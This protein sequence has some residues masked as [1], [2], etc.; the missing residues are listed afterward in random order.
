MIFGSFQA[1]LDELERRGAFP[2]GPGALRVTGCPGACPALLAAALLDR[3]TQ[4]V[5]FVAHSPSQAEAALLDIQTGAHVRGAR[6]LP[7][8]ETLPF[9]DSDPHVEITS[10]R[11]D[12]FSALLSGR[13]RLV[14]TTARGLVERSPVAVRGED[15]S[16]TL[17]EG[18]TWSRS[19]LADRLRA[20]GFESAE[21]VGEL[22]EF[23]VRG[24]I[25]D[26]FPFGVDRPFRIELWDDSI[27]SI[28]SFDL[29]SQR[30]V[31][32]HDAAEILPVSLDPELFEAAHAKWE[33]RCLLELLPDGAVLVDAGEAASGSRHERLWEEV[34]EAWGMTRPADGAR[35]RI[36]SCPR[37]RR[38][39]GSKR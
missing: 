35:P 32:R 14:V 21:S 16:I 2:G 36:S 5:V 34:R 3:G 12:A 6:L 37:P 8:R 18:D 11:V 33:R 26:V 13:T 28:R 7:Q 19:N 15:F 23:A 4:P 38:A 22:G 27:A 10:Q 20:M 31:E 24:G 25:V 1:H 30:S 17:R 29:L 39:G 9:E